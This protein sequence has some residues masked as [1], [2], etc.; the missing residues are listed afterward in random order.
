MASLR[1][2]R[3]IVA[4]TI[5]ASDSG[6]GAGIQGDLATFAALGVY[7]ISVL[8]AGTAQNTRG[9]GAVEPF[10]AAFVGS[11]MD[12]VLP[13]FRPAA[14]KIGAL[15]DGA[16]VRAVAAGL[17]RHNPPNV[18]LDPVLAAKDGSPLLAPR[19]LAT[20]RREL[21]PLCDLVTPNLPEAEALAR[22]PIR[23]SSDRRLAA[24]ILAD[25]GPRAVLIK[26]GHDRG[27]LLQDL[28]F[29]GRRFREFQHPRIGTGA[30]H[31]TGC[32]LSA[33]IAANLALGLSLDEA[34]GSAID[35]V[36][37]AIREPIFP[38]RGRAVPN[39][40]VP[41][42]GSPTPSTETRTRERRTRSRKRR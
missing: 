19:A 42:A 21:L 14:V 22:I 16:R 17:K 27:A 10:S 29:D 31:G 25:A 37:A 8:T 30:V 2:P 1:R 28:L 12:S 35:W 4:L 39:R 38:G 36:Q 24:G 40:F 26:G 41:V 33:A 3:P 7:G 13:D 15:Y 32:A 5:A 9:I 18:V 6:G 34:V 23:D 11:Q 20:L